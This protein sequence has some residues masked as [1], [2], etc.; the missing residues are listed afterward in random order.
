MYY[1]YIDYILQ[2]SYE[3]NS[4][5]ALGR[6][7]RE[8]NGIGGEFGQTDGRKTR[9]DGTNE[10][11]RYDEVGGID[12]QHQTLSSRNRDGTSNLRLDD[13]PSPSI[14]EQFKLFEQAAVSNMTTQTDRRG[15]SLA[16]KVRKNAR[17]IF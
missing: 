8:S 14:K 4:D 11:R 17:A 12:E 2:S 9:L 15:K 5:S 10:S 13:K 6:S 1:I 16:L 7:S 3:R